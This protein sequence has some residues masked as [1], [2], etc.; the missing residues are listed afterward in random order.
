MLRVNYRG[1]PVA[2]FGEL[3]AL[4]FLADAYN[5]GNDSNGLSCFSEFVTW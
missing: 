4:I 3:T 5:H 1:T 2:M